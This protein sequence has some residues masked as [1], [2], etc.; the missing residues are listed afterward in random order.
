MP[1]SFLN[2]ALLLGLLAASLPVIIHFLSRR[3]TRRVVFSDLRFLQE[4]EAQQA[5]RRGVQR[6]LLLLLRVLIVCC[7]VLAAARPHWGGLPGG[8]GRAVLF[9]IDASASMQ[10]QAEDGRTRFA[11][12]VELA[13]GMVDGLPTG[14]SV[15]VVTLSAAAQPLFASWL[16]AGTPVQTAL[17]AAA[18]TDGP[19]DLAV[20]LREAARQI[21]QAPSRPVEV[22]LLSDLQAV[23][24]PELATAAA[25]LAAAGARLL[26]QRL[27]D[28]IPGGGVLDLRLPGRA[29][30][31]GEAT[32]I[33]AVVRPER[34]EQ[35][36][37][38]EL[39]GRRIAEVLAPPPAPDG[40]GVSLSFPLAA[41][42]AGLHLG[43]IG[44]EED[45]LPADDVRPFV[46]Q[47]PQRLEVLLAHGA[48]RDGLGRGGWRYLARALD[49]AADAQGL[50]R[51]RTLPADSLRDGDLAGVDLLVLVDPGPPGRRLNAALASWLASGG[52]LLLMVG[53]AA[54]ETDLRD[55]WLPLLDLPRQA[56]WV[57]REDGQAERAAVVDAAHPVLAGLGAEPLKALTAARWSRY[58]ALEEGPARVVLATDAGAP[59]LL[60][61]RRGEG[62][63]ALLPFHLRRDA[64]DVMLNPV[65][66]PLIQRLAATLATGGGAAAE[67]VVG[68]Q[69]VLSLDPHE[70]GL[71]P[72]D[73]TDRLVVRTPPDGAVHRA[74]LLWRDGAAVLAAP[75]EER[76]GFYVFLGGADTLGVVAAVVPASESS[77]QV[78]APETVADR[79]RA[80]GISR[81]LDLGDG[82]P[83]GLGQ[84][85]AGRD[86]ARWLL[87]A[88]LIL[89]AAELWLGRRVRA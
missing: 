82:G 2:P 14:S 37:W 57:V 25:E 71:R 26:V 28:G 76:A 49:P 54:Q 30:R 79:L 10:A 63:W 67:V 19:A 17:T 32:E 22:V 58:F 24:Q 20:G 69:P 55:G 52:A 43:R 80:A 1:L 77:P 38:L 36:F 53:D 61:G 68:E 27:G 87:V 81:V 31:P 75:R 78:E 46:L 50:F 84:A 89:M 29:L 13:A 8:G 59:L 65:F 11:T 9:L 70:L 45:R 16:P 33:T 47:V 5:Q 42:P 64:T 35:P 4:E 66:L 7:L 83:E 62:R 23:A 60:E 88:A 39:D 34:A 3:R 74:A 40:G 85:L 48:D 56:T 51:V 73:T 86:L 72:G 41:P 21:R 44:K 12:A 6:W 18:V 15:Q